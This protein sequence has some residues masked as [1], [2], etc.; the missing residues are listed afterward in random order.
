MMHS[1]GNTRT[2][3]HIG[4]YLR[5]FPT[6]KQPLGYA[7]ASAIA[8]VLASTAHGNFSILADGLVFGMTAFLYYT[9]YLYNDIIDI[10]IDAINANDRPLASG[11]LTKHQ[12][13][14]M[15]G[16]FSAAATACMLAAIVATEVSAS[17]LIV[18]SATLLAAVTLGIAYS[19]PRI[20]LKRRFPFK[21][22]SV[23][24]GAALACLAGWAVSDAPLNVEILLASTATASIIFAM[25]IL[26]DMRDIKGDSLHD[27]RT[28]PI[29]LGLTKST[30]IVYMGLAYPALISVALLPAIG[31]NAGVLSLL[32]LVAIGILG[33]KSVS[34]ST[35]DLEDRKAFMGSMAKMR[36]FFYIGQAGLVTLAVRPF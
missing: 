22:L 4:R 2:S 23:A 18:I 17:G 25:S 35:R 26:F 27:V 16:I 3:Y 9:I 24:A 21:S 32:A 11:A 19:N 13:E 8:Y 28:F 36:L 6:K 34:R 12:A 7:T 20:Y 10:D 15:L 29:V 33:A 30:K 1:K 31:F 14:G 5:I